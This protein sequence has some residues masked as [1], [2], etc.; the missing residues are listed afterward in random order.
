MDYTPFHLD[1]YLGVASVL[2]ASFALDG[3]APELLTQMCRSVSAY[4]PLFVFLLSTFVFVA[5]MFGVGVMRA[6]VAHSLA[7]MWRRITVVDIDSH[8]FR[9]EGWAPW[10]RKRL[11]PS[12]LPPPVE[13]GPGLA[14]GAM[15]PL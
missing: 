9:I 13:Y 2:Y 6:A 3:Y 11:R 12:Y 4:L 7:L 8:W 1:N 15:S 10:E 14:A 5:G